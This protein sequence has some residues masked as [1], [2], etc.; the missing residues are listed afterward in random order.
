MDNR[1]KRGRSVN[2]TL[3]ETDQLVNLI[4][5]RR[6]IIES[7]KNDAETWLSKER[8]WKAIEAE[9]N[10]SPTGEVYR[11]AKNLKIKY[12]SMKKD[13]RK[14]VNMQQAGDASRA[15]IMTPFEERMKEMCEVGDGNCDSELEMSQGMYICC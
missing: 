13:I 2:F 5:A 12:E 6:H 11:T 1:K 14:K 4:K 3:G 15:S 10:T 9:F 7:K 8:A